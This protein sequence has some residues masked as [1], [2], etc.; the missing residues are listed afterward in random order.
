MFTEIIGNLSAPLL[1][2]IILA[3]AL[4]N[5]INIF[6]SFRRGAKEGLDCVITIMPAVIA[7]I[8]AV[9]MFKSSGMMDILCNLVRPIAEMMGIPK[10]CVPLI[11]MKPI[12]GSGSNAILMSIFSQCG[13]DSIV[14]N[15]ASIISGSVEALFY[16]YATYLCKRSENNSY[17]FIIF[18]I[19]YTLLCSSTHIVI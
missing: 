5:R 18:F 11:I 10:E 13:P 6:E 1:M 3:L 2:S 9:T 12:S 8:T 14:G 7:L 15:I 4:K 17:I 16:I 19:I